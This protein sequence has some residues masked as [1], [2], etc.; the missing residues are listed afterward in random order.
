MYAIVD[1]ETTGGY[2]A[3]N[4]I[5]EISIQIFD[6]EKVTEQYETLINPH[7]TIPR[8]IQAFT[9]ITN[10]MVE[11]A[12]SFEEVAEQVYTILQGNIF[13]AH[14]VNFD[15]SFVKNHL[16]F[17][18]Y[19]F[20]AKKLCTVRLSRQIFPGFPSYSLGN[21]CTSLGIELQNRHRAG[22][23]AAATVQLF[24]MMLEH[25]AKGYIQTA[26]HRN[27]KDAV[28]PPN[29][30]MADFDALPAT[31][32]VY[33]FLDNK[34]K[35]VYVGK[36]KN[37]KTRVNSHF[38]NNSDSKQKQNFLKHIHHIRFQST[39][40][41]LMA[42]I[43]ESAEIKRLWPIFNTSQKR[44]EDVYGIFVYE[45]QNRYMRL[46]TEKRRK[47][48][49]PI[50]TFH[51]KVD[52]HGVMRKV[53][54][55]F[56]L[57]PKLCFIQ[58]SNDTCIGMEEGYCKGACEKKEVP[59]DYN[60]RVLQA[61]ASLTKR[62]SYVVLDKGLNEDEISCI[63]VVKGNFFGMGY[64]P[65]DFDNITYE[66]IAEYITPYKENSYIRNVLNAFYDNNPDKVRLLDDQQPPI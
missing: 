29:V 27:S 22:G 19:T 44:Q 43:L 46:A 47:G 12:P 50:Y 32:G 21:L 38:S 58:T 51:Y 31:P 10:E 16:D 61:I 45:D 13:V 53:M 48:S 14:N 26:L 7:Q 62:P 36:A 1:I 35:V 25:D 52:G 33:Y 6:G 4:G 39:A 2:A 66:A 40:T 63:M 37:I 18:G 34:E 49:N 64:L 3:A 42:E 8:Y 55:E 11:D 41:E 15:Y 59:T 60:E 20:N 23:D 57:C 65:K 28:L 54:Q 5:I 24:K 9:G 17:Y 56:S 30:P